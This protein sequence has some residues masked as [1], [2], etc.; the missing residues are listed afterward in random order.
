MGDRKTNGAWT[1]L[2]SMT[3]FVRS[4]GRRPMQAPFAVVEDGALVEG[5]NADAVV[6]WWSFTKTVI[7]AAALV[8]VQQNRLDLDRPLAGR[9]Y[10]L[11]QLLLHRAGLTDYGALAAYHQAVAA[12]DE[13]WPAAVLLERTQAERLRYEPGQGWGYS[14]IGYLFVRELIERACDEE[15]GAALARLVLRPLGIEEARLARV[16][17][18]LDGVTMGIRSYHP[19]W[20]YHGLLVGPLREAALLLDR[21]MTGALLSPV[22][23]DEMRDAHPLDVSGQGHQGHQARPWHAPA[24]GLGLMGGVTSNGTR[25]FG[26]TGGGPGSVIA[27]YRL[28]DAEPPY[29]AAAF[30]FGED[31]A[32]VEGRT[33]KRGSATH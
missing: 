10:S 8:L 22:L 26:H 21:L 24:Y 33:L 7:A 2:N 27:V 28:P 30:A 31:P 17:A 14:N 11:Q 3:G 1:F 13:P 29:T 4:G 5:T 23:L 6:P 25:A 16:H 19:G 12:D 18:D 20:V 32:P 15:L 9:R